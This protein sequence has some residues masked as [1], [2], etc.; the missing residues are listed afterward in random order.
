MQA[1]PFRV[2]LRGCSAAPCTRKTRSLVHWCASY[3]CGG[4]VS[5]GGWVLAGPR[6]PRTPPASGSQARGRLG[7]RR[8]S[9]WGRSWCAAASLTRIAPVPAFS[10]S[11]G[12]AI[13]SQLQPRSA[14]S[15]DCNFI[16]WLLER[17]EAAMCL[18]TA[19]LS[20]HAKNTYNS[21]S[22]ATVPQ[23]PSMADALSRPCHTGRAR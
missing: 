23:P 12:A 17:T 5:H 8:R 6:L 7:R 11:L 18:A 19:R 9:R 22:L 10:V 21:R 13:H 20:S 1:P 16:V 15:V 3:T 2:A 4:C 14:S